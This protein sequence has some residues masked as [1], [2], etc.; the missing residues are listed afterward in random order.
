MYPVLSVTGS[1]K[2]RDF[3]VDIAIHIERG[4]TVLLGPSGH[5]K[6]TV[7]N[8]IAG[9]ITPDS[10]VISLGN[11]PFFD[12]DRGINVDME[13]RNIGYVFQDY[14]LF[15]HL[16]VFEN[17][18]FGLRA[19]HL[20]SGTIRMRVM[21]ELE[22]LGIA[23][24]QD[25]IPSRLSAGQCQ[26]VALARTIVIEP[27]ILLMD[28]PLSA[29]DT[30]LRARVRN[31]LKILLRQ[32]SIP[33]LIVTHDALDAIGLGDTVM[34]M[35]QGRIV[36]QGTY[37]ALLAQ[38]A[39]RFVAE[40][41]ESNAYAGQL[42]SV[43]GQGEAIVTL[44]KGIDIHAVLDDAQM[45]ECTHTLLVVIHPWDVALMKTP[46]MGSIDNV[47]QGEI[48]GIFPL[49]DRVRVLIDAGIRI[50]A[51]MTRVSL[52]ALKLKEGSVVHAGFKAMAVRVFPL[53]DQKSQI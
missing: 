26:R 34:V 37:D 49:R 20:P 21:R 46:A 52:D 44:E 23:S 43:N 47:L 15:P 30:Q 8:M 3:T 5:G 45:E 40:F 50:I 17:V 9:I 36:Q 11:S 41:V 6:T 25:E 2:R 1:K 16:S 7:L 4:V 31:E 53:E 24:L 35:E 38:P 28:E 39:S 18:A 42:K 51:E 19:R 27:C 10:G 33:T 13:K 12:A 48:L 14:A 29:L 22:R 32:L